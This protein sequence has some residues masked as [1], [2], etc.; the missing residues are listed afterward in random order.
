MEVLLMTDVVC[1][2]CGQY[3]F[4]EEFELCLVCDWQYDKIQIKDP[5]YWGGLNKLSINDFRKEWMRKSSAIVLGSSG[6]EALNQS[7]V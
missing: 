7:R 6:V 1:P 2:V 3:V 4:T 5:D